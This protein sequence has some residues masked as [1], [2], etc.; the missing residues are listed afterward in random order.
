MNFSIQLGKL[1]FQLG[2]RNSEPGTKKSC[3]TSVQTWLD[4]NVTSPATL[5]APYE[6]S[7]WVYTAVSA[8]ARPSP[9][10]PSAFHGGIAPAKTFSPPVSLD[11]MLDLRQRVLAQ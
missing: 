2:T 7:V 10:S 8:L 4:G 6:Q 9:P 11:G 1:N 5:V 3:T